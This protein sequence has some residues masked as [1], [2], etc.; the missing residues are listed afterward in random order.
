M[1]G[2]TGDLARRK[3]IPSLYHRF[4][5]GQIPAESK[6]IGASRS[7]LTRD[8][9]L[10][11]IKEAYKTFNPDV[12]LVEKEWDAF[13]AL[14]DYAPI[15]VTTDKDWSGLGDKLDKTEKLIRVFYLAMPP[16]LFS[17]ICQGL[18]KASLAHK[19]SRVVLE[20]PLG[21]DFKSADDINEAVGKVF[22]EKRIYR[23]CLL[24]TS[25]S[26]RDRG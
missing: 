7:N 25:P 15:D 16:A 24:Y 21:H 12:T 26:P 5:D 17:D 1:F 11:M 6:I 3:L 4:C 19:K 8:E 22:S 23:I 2:G 10:A 9:Y 20:K 13:S 14:V 18:K